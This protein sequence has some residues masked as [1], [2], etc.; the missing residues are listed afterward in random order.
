MRIAYYGLNIQLNPALAP[1]RSLSQPSLAAFL[2]FSQRLLRFDSIYCLNLAEVDENRTHQ[3]RDTPR[4]GF[5]DR[6]P[7]QRTN[8]LRNI[9]RG[10]LRLLGYFFNIKFFNSQEQLKLQ[11]S[12][13]QFF[14]PQ[15]R[16][17]A[18]LPT[19]Q[20]LELPPGYAE[21]RYSDHPHYGL[22]SPHP[23]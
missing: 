17:H 9:F 16:N 3:G 1:L 15:Q 21:F 10:I 8:Y 18:P 7:H 12:G 22:S 5:E 19:G 13:H 20:L 4:I 11:K 6:E 23:D 2:T 14:H